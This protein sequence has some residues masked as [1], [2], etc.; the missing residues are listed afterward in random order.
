MLLC[1]MT[2]LLISFD[3]NVSTFK[4]LPYNVLHS[5]SFFG[6]WKVHRPIPFTNRTSALDMRNALFVLQPRL[7]FDSPLIF[8]YML[9]T[10]PSNI[11]TFT[12]R[13]L[14]ISR[15]YCML[16]TNCCSITSHIFFWHFFPI[17]CIVFPYSLDRH[18]H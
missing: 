8:L 18:L 6:R 12:P 11:Q 15:K 5:I 16:C 9:P 2:K 7:T 10:G 1:R 4:E 13:Y 14:F 3:G 17:L